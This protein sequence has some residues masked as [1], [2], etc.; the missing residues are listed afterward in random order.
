LGCP[1]D[2]V[3][4]VGVCGNCNHKNGRLDRALLTPYEIITVI[5]GVPRKKGRRPTV[6]GFASFASGYDQNGPVL[7]VN[8]EKYSVQTPNG[9][10]LK[11]TNAEDPI[12]DAKWEHRPDG[13]VSISYNQELRF[14][15][16]AV[17]GLFKIAIEAIAFYE[18][19]EVARDPSLLPA[20]HFVLNGDGNFRAI[21]I[22]DQSLAYDH[23]FSPCFSKEGYA[24]VFGMTLLGIGFCCDFDPEFRGGEMLLTELRKQSMQGQVVPNWPRRLWLE[25]NPPRG[26]R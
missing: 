7:Y 19:L 10:W 26:C 16:K 18:G 17:R 5:K 11:G 6:D 2:F 21:M 20:K 24:R 8:R 12:K 25:N 1:P 4:T 3:L 22:P 9:K 13:T 15:R 23:Y 14:D